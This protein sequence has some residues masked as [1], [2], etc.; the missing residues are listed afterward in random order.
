MA[1]TAT[2]RKSHAGRPVVVTLTDILPTLRG[3][4][5]DPLDRTR[6][7]AETL[8]TVDDVAV[9]GLSLARTARLLGTPLVFRPA[10]GDPV[11]VVALT[12]SGVTA[13]PEARRVLCGRTRLSSTVC[14]CGD[15][16]CWYE[17]RLVGRVS[18]THRRPATLVACGAE[19]TV[20]LPVDLGP[21]D[22]IAIPVRMS[23]T[24]PGGCRLLDRIE[25]SP[26]H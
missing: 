22:V 13:G 8:A 14:V 17:A 3:S 24:A 6:W 20:D 5:P 16:M 1:S 19:R 21:G 9:Q 15:E 23:P 18:V 4:L 12:V 7:P 26:G 25:D 10:A 11:G 2:E